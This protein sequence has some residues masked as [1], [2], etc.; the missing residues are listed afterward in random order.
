MTKLKFKFNFSILAILYSSDGTYYEE[1]N[2]IE[3][4]EEISIEKNKIG[5]PLSI[6][7]VMALVALAPT[8]VY[9]S[10]LLLGKKSFRNENEEYPSFGKYLTS[11]LDRSEWSNSM[12]Y[13]KMSKYTGHLVDLGI[14][15][16]LSYAFTKTHLGLVN[17]QNEVVRKN[18]ELLSQNGLLKRYREENLFLKTR[19]CLSVVSCETIHDSLLPKIIESVIIDLD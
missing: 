3:I 5:I 9:A 17:C 6:I 12:K 8:K 1:E 4:I 16:G 14:G 10:Y 15:V 13:K 11:F 7:C 2:S 18:L 19:E